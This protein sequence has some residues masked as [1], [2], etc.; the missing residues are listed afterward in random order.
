MNKPTGYD[1]ATAQTGGFEQLPP[2]AYNCVI[3]AAY[4][5]Q[6][7]SGK[8]MLQLCVDIAD[9]D[10]KEYFKNQYGRD[11]RYGDAKWRGTYYQ[12][13]E[14]DSLGYFKGL[15]QDIEDSN[16][17]YKFNFDENT[18]A[19][20]KIGGVF[21]REQY[22]NQAGELKFAVK[23]F[24]CVASSRVKDIAPPKDKLLSGNGNGGSNGN[25]YSA[26]ANMEEID[27][28]SDLPF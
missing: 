17:G 1:Q 25:G 27:V 13:T 12:L 7:N 28:D 24:Y 20:K 4:E 6:S 9:G 8:N 18:L 19:G 11:Q 21:G 26:P 10:F 16:P 14:G 23:C 22:K 15:I 5:S 2:G 3:K